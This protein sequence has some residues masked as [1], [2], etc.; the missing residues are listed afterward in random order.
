MHFNTI[1]LDPPWP[2]DRTYGQGIAENTYEV[3]TW[4]EIAALGAALHRVMAPHCAVLCWVTAPLLMET[5]D[6]LRAWRMRYITKAFTWIKL[7]ADS[8]V[9]VGL[10]SHSRGNSEDVWLLSN[11]TPKRHAADV[12]QVIHS[13]NTEHSRKPDEAYRRAERLYPGPYLEVFA[14]RPRD[15][16]TC[17]GNEID[18]RD[19]FDALRDV[20]AAEQPPETPRP[21]VYNLSLDTA[22]E[23]A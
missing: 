1:F 17:V 23:A 20:A 8:G 19:V 9:Y 10:G 5:T 18:G 3:M 14:R 21:A 4:P 22:Q 7:Y 13:L 15:G 11:G 12:S 6:A 16:W 2:Y